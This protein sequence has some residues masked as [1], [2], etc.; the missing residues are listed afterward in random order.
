ALAEH[1]LSFTLLTSGINEV[2]KEQHT[3]KVLRAAAAIGVKRFRMAYYKYDL[4]KP[5][6]AQLEEFRAKMRDLVAATDEIGIKPIY[7]NH[8]GKNYFGGPLWDLADILDEFS[9]DQA[10]VAFD[11]GHATVE[12]AKAW[13]LN[14]A[15]VRPWVDMVYLKEPHWKDNQLS[16]GA[17]GEGAVDEGFYK[18]LKDSDFTGPISLHVEYLGRGPEKEA[19]IRAAMEKDL[20]TMRRLIG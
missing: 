7:Q 20:A 18:T 14:W 11:I 17:L 16:W 13:P 3:E 6:P 5:I 1:D 12:G 19:T 4:S 8:S 2:S 10:G 9:P 15:R